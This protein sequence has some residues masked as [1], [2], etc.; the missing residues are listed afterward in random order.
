MTGGC[1]SWIEK[2]HTNTRSHTRYWC[3]MLEWKIILHT[4]SS[5]CSQLIQC[6]SIDYTF[7]SKMFTHIF[8]ASAKRIRWIGSIHIDRIS[9]GDLKI[10]PHLLNFC[11]CRCC[12]SRNKKKLQQKWTQQHQQQQH[13]DKENAWARVFFSRSS[14]RHLMLNGDSAQ[15]II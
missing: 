12:R 13:D 8:N 15:M 6:H 2:K 3:S 1:S 7:A 5:T 10:F 9:G 14:F 4:C 11:S